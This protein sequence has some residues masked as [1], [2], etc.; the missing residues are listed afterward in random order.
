MFQG[1]LVRPTEWQV[2]RNHCTKTK[3]CLVVRIFLSG[4]GGVSWWE[5]DTDPQWDLHGH[6][7]GGS[8]VCKKGSLLL[9]TNKL[10][11]KILFAKFSHLLFAKHSEVPCRWIFRFF[12]SIHIVIKIHIVGNKLHNI[13][14]FPLFVR[15]STNNTKEVRDWNLWW[16][17]DFV[18]LTPGVCVVHQ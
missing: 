4:V 7:L 10:T 11:I 3:V 14:M 6:V 9:G 18:L 5:A 15:P 2:H 16:D 12:L 17:W 1:P 8:T 13:S